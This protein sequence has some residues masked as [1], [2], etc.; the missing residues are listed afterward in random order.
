MKKDFQR[1]LQLFG[2]DPLHTQIDDFF[3]IIATFLV[4]FEVHKHYLLYYQLC[5][6]F[7]Y[8]MH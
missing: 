4:D 7:A 6:V 8:R 1:A 3:S 5:N 2:E